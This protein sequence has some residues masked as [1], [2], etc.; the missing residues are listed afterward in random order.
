MA[1]QAKAGDIGHGVHTVHLRQLCA[2]PVELGGV[3]QHLGI[4]VGPQQAF[5]QR[6]RQHAHAQRLAQ[7]QHV[8]GAAIGSVTGLGAEG[9][10][11]ALRGMVSALRRRS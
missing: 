10:E 1:G 6:G 5:F 8:A 4:A 2:H 7:N 3:A 11:F 9:Y